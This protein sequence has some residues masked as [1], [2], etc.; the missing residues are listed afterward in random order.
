MG[1]KIVA[2]KKLE[3]NILTRHKLPDPPPPSPAESNGRPLNFVVMCV[4]SV[5][6]TWG[7][8]RGVLGE[9]AFV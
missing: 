2:G 9:Y 4:T 3:R 6:F 7:V 8:L 1:I 5:G